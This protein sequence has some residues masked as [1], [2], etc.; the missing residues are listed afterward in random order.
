MGE[1]APT[2]KEFVMATQNEQLQRIF[3][4]YVEA[5]GSTPTTMEDV[6]KWAI[7]E[8]LWKPRPSDILRRCAS[9]LA[10]ALRQEYFTDQYG[11]RVRAKHAA[12]MERKGEQFVFWD[13]IRTAPRKHMEVAFKQRRE[14]IVSDC[15]QLK[16]D[17]DSSNNAHPEEP[18][19]QMIFDFRRDLEE[20]EQGAA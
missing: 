1:Y 16:T 13:D 18:R 9:D 7:N 3:R 15:R 4:M 2:I 17:A 19:I 5:G 20:L 11:R 12:R 10:A 6:A 14:Q 8:N